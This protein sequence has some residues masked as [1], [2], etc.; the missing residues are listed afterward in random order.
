M[1]SR[2]DEFSNTTRGYTVELREEQDGTWSALVP[3]LPGS[4][5]VGQTP[6]GA[7]ADL[8]E[9][10]D[11]WIETAQERG[12]AVPAPRVDP[13][14]SGR[15]LLRI[16][17]DLHRA[18]V[19]RARVE[20]VSLNTYMVSA[21]SAAVG[22]SLGARTRPAAAAVYW[23]KLEA[24]TGAPG[25]G[26]TRGIFTDESLRTGYHFEPNFDASGLLE[27]SQLK[28]ATTLR[29]ATGAAGR[30]VVYRTT[31]SGELEGVLGS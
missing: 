14:V 9:V 15:V 8:P 28:A 31:P 30:T 23:R 13:E 27:L 16:P 25:I 22:E 24:V 19:N 11:L 21:L 1:S 17:R 7:M 3:E 29:V 4:V 26:R 2:P 20:G 12:M 18:L 5:A 6:N 10:I